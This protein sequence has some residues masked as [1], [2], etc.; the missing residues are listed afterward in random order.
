MAKKEVSSGPAKGF[1]KKYFIGSPVQK[2]FLFYS[3]TMGFLSILLMRLHDYVL[4]V[5]GE[6]SLI[7]AVTIGVFGI[8]SVYIAVGLLLSN[9]IAG[10]LY[11]IENTLKTFVET[12]E[13]KEIKLRKGDLF[14]DLADFLN[15]TMK[16]K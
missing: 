9:R 3:V 8:F 6:K 1:R 15:Q 10:P 14:S 16:K 11:R 4:M 2:V 7:S 12:G 5:A 13:F